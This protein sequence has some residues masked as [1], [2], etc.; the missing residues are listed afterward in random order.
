MGDCEEVEDWLLEEVCEPLSDCVN[1]E[2]PVLDA[3]SVANCVNVAVCEGERVSL[4][5]SVESP[6]AVDV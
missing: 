1:E 6:D 2:L 4:C 3:L 5:D